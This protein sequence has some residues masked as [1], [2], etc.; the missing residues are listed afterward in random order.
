MLTRTCIFRMLIVLVGLSAFAQ[1]Q[2]AVAQ[3]KANILR[4]DYGRYRA[5]SDLLYYH[6]DVRVDPEKKTIR[7]KN[8]IRF[9]MLKD[10]NRIQLDLHAALEVDKILLGETELKYERDSGAVFVDFPETLKAGRDVAIDFYYSG[11][12]FQGSRFGGFTFGKDPKGRPWIYTAC[13]GPG[14]SI[15]WPNKDQWRDKVDSMDISVTIP[16]GLVDVSNGKFAGKKDLGDGTTRWDWHVSYP[17]NNY[18]VS[19]N[20]GAYEHFADKFGDLDLDF[21]ALPEDLD[22]AKAQ[23]SQVKGMLKTFTHYFG[24][25][26]FKNDGYKLIQV[27]YSGMEHQSAVTYGNLFK[28]GYLGRDWTGVGISPRFDFIIVHESGH[29]WFGNSVSA[30][31]RSDMWIHEGWTTYLEALYVEYHWGKADALK[32]VN[33]Y[34]SRIKNNQ[35]IVSRRGINANPP[36]DQYFKG[37]L[38]LNTLRSIVD[39]DTRWW[40]LL[41]DFYQRFKYQAIMTEDI[42]AYFNKQ[43]GKN[44]TPVFDQY[45]RHAALPVLE[46]KFD[47]AAVSYRWKADEKAFAMPVRVGAPDNWQIITPRAEW[48]SLKSPLKKDEFQVATDLY[49]VAVQKTENASHSSG[50]SLPPLPSIKE[51]VLFNTPEADK[52]LTAMQVFPATNAWNEDISQRP[53]HPN[54]KNLIASAGAEKPLLYNLDMSFI[55]VPPDQKKV[56]IKVVQYPGESDLAPYPIPDNAPIEDWPLNGKKLDII[57]REGK[58]DRHVVVVD[59]VNAKLYELYIG[60]KT[61]AGWQ[62]AQSST[63]DLKSNALR[64]D[65]WTSTDAAGLPIFPAIIRYD[66]LERGLVEHAMRFTVKNSRRAYVYPATHFASK[67]TDENMPRMGERYRLRADFDTTGYSSHAKAILK[68]LQKYGMI[69]ADNGGDWRLSVAPDSRIKGL[70]E[71]RKV[72]GKDFEVIVP[73]GPNEGP[74]A[75]K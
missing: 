68:G 20:I 33:G 29:E 32:Y 30:A 1:P 24:E 5:N 61:D 35:P 71:L 37:A 8:T 36:G 49:Y 43:T 69:V 3:S 16:N 42:V 25:Y 44:L 12:P 46:L 15:W 41:R 19:L 6:L 7:G 13:E 47:D 22:R 53:V 14:A 38:F 27:P 34:K 39:D 9:K 28:N 50:R 17:I 2:R 72:K 45:L 62:A 52:I 4:G 73:T 59:P 66:E 75:K 51:P 54:S 58:G 18:C 55:I 23:F 63:F 56:P 11:T 31:D 60:R 64:P 57:Q 40:A 70:D 65:G 67:K 48:Q 21:Y 26:P 74:R 10:D